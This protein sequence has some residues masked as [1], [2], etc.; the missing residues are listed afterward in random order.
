MAQVGPGRGGQ[1]DPCAVVEGPEDPVAWRFSSTS[2]I[3]EDG[4]HAIQLVASRDVVIK[5]GKGWGGGEVRV[6]GAW[7]RGTLVLEQRAMGTSK[8]VRLG[9]ASAHATLRSLLYPMGVA[10]GLNSLQVLPTKSA[11]RL[12]GTKG[13]ARVSGTVEAQLINRLFTGR[14]PASVKARFGG[15]YNF[16][17]RE[18]ALTEVT[19]LARSRSRR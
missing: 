5:V 10:S 9:V 2:D 14:R 16:T 11:V 6:P 8:N 13:R 18:G 1:G 17:D 7:I 12:H 3:L 19:I 4:L 15:W